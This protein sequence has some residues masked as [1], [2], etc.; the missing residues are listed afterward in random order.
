[1]TSNKIF[2]FLAVCSLGKKEQKVPPKKKYQKVEKCVSENSVV[3]HNHL[4][5]SH[6]ALACIPLPD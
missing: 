4:Q 3:S 5:S 2:L 6:P 1:M